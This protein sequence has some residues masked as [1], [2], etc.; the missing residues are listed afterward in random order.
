MAVFIGL[1]IHVTQWNLWFIDVFLIFYGKQLGFMARTNKLYQILASQTKL[2]SRDQII[3]DFI[4]FWEF[5]TVK[6]LLQTNNLRPPCNAN[7]KSV[8]ASAVFHTEARFFA[9]SSSTNNRW[10]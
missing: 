1:D 3:V 6:A 4:F 9:I 10:L 5:S 8:S 7:M 2:V